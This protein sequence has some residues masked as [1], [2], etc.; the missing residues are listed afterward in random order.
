M[1]RPLSQGSRAQFDFQQGSTKYPQFTKFHQF[2]AYGYD[3]LYNTDSRA[4]QHTS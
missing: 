1:R 4:S 3:P 2:Q